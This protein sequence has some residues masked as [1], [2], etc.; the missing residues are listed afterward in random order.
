M[1][2]SL[3]QGVHHYDHL[4]S[5]VRTQ[6]TDEVV[7]GGE[8]RLKLLTKA[9]KDG[10]FIVNGQK[11]EYLGLK[12]ECFD[13]T[14]LWGSAFKFGCCLLL[15]SGG[16]RTSSR[17]PRVRRSMASWQIQTTSD[18]MSNS[19]LEA[20]FVFACVRVSLVSSWLSCS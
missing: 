14:L 7:V 19:V 17:R 15:R 10:C 11:E 9:M 1:V 5:F 8:F 13:W 4:P 3:W 2:M 18:A 12:F 20:M 6:V 16:H